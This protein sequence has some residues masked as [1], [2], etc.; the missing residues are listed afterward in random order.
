MYK[1]PIILALHFLLEFNCF[2]LLCYCLL[3]NEVSQLYVYIYLLPLGP[4][5]PPVLPIQVI[6]EHRA[7]L[8]VLYSGFYV[9]YMFN[10]R[11]TCHLFLYLSTSLTCSQN[12]IVENGLVYHLF[13]FSILIALQPYVCVYDILAILR[14]SVIC[15][16]EIFF[17]FLKKTFLPM[18]MGM[19]KFLGLFFA[20]SNL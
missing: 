8:S 15:I 6:T 3:Y 7:E 5:F 2:T 14:N 13:S 18:H 12:F 4:L 17:F 11:C 19:T 10:V 16:S 20:F 1:I 9:M